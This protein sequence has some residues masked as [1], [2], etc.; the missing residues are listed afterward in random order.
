[1]TDNL[2]YA[3]SKRLTQSQQ[4]SCLPAS[5][6]PHQCA[7]NNANLTLTYVAHST[8]RVDVR[9]GKQGLAWGHIFTVLTGNRARNQ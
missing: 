7:L 5:P 8:G 1:M 3:Q 4:E 6:P 9:A 2:F